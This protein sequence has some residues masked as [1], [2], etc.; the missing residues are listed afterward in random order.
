MYKYFV[1]QKPFNA[2]SQFTSKERK[3]TLKDFFNVPVNVYP[4]GRLDYYSEGLFI[5]TDDKYL[6][7]Y[8][9]NPLQKNEREYW[10]QI[11]AIITQNAI[12]DLQQGVNIH[13]NGKIFL[14]KK[15]LAKIAERNLPIRFIKIYPK[16]G[17]N[18]SE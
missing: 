4:V 7:D 16:D 2:L 5:L 3:K 12:A 14:T 9:L 15:C 18:D 11:E 1:I 10:V 17:S 13:S 8:L 6:N